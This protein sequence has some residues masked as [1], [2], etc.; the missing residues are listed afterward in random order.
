MK[1]ILAITIV[2][3][4]FI[5]SWGQSMT[6]DEVIGLAQKQSLDMFRSKNMY[7]SS[8]WEYKSYKASQLPY[9]DMHF[10]PATYNRNMTRRYDFENDV[11]VYREQQTLSSYTNFSLNQNIPLTGGRIYF[12]SDFSRLVNYGDKDITTYSTTPI[13]IGLQ[14]PLFAFNNLK[15]EKKI[16]PIKFEKSKQEYIQNVQTTNIKAVNLFFNLALASLRKEIAI[17]NI[18]TADTL[19]KVGEKRFAIAS[20]QR[21]ELLDLEL[22]KF[23]AEIDL[24]KAESALEKARFN[25]N[26]FLGLNES[27]IIKPVIPE[28]IENL[29]I[30]VKAAIEL[31]KQLNPHMLSMQQK[32]LEAARELDKAKKE[33]RFNANLWASYGLNQSAAELNQAYKDPLSQQMVMF[34]MDIPLVDWGERKGKKQMA[35]KQ[36]EVTDIETKQEEID[37]EETVALKIIDFN[38]QEKVVQSAAKANILAEES[39]SL[40]KKRFLLGKAD[41]LKLNSS[42]KARQSASENYL[43]SLYSFWK[44]YYEVQ[45]LTLYSFTNKKA[46][47]EDFDTMVK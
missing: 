38:L 44:Y 29:K 47:S 46:I 35:Q 13:R 17:N 43:A 39:F 27:N 23:N 34:A 3:F 41:V 31:A 40:T 30:E 6:L 11:E 9:I 7:L 10:N 37:F 32:R 22:S 19:Y 45:Q 33:S 8:Y 4:S 2:L 20:I 24:A 1:K 12:D 18:S 21:E 15:W 14:Q 36:K 16:S 28:I 25:A 26:S 42:M 5:N